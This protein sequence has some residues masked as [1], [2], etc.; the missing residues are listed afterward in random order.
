VRPSQSRKP[1]VAALPLV[2]ALP[3]VILIFDGAKPS[4]LQFRGPFLEMLFRHLPSRPGLEAEA[5]LEIDNSRS[6]GARRLAEV[7]TANVI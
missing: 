2:A 5:G 7:A 6:E 1:R 3:F 4:D